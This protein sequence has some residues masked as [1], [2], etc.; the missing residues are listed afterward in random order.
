VARAEAH[1]AFPPDLRPDFI[2]SAAVV[3]CTAGFLIRSWFPS[4]GLGA[5][6]SASLCRF[7]VRSSLIVVAARE[8]S[9]QDVIDFVSAVHGHRFPLGIFSAV[10]KSRFCSPPFLCFPVQIDFFGGCSC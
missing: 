7:L 8:R 2:F 3:V 4:P 9:V 10:L 1:P 5:Q 6:F